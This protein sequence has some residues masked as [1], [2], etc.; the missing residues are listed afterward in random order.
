MR[1]GCEAAS[2]N[3]PKA[4]RRRCAKGSDE[5]AQAE[6]LIGDSIEGCE[7]VEEKARESIGESTEESEGIRWGE[8]GT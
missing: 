7:S 5:S 8:R 2:E 6:E 3:E 1:G 4:R